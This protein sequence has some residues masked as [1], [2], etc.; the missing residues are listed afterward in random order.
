MIK[1]C[2]QKYCTGCTACLNICPKEC[3]QMVQNCDGFKYPKIEQIRCVKCG[4]CQK[5]CPSLS[6]KKVSTKTFNQNAYAATSRKSDVLAK[7]AS[8]GVFYELAKAI[9]NEGG[10]VFGAAYDE[11]MIVKHIPVYSAETLYLLQGTKYV[12]S[13]LGTCFSLVKKNLAEGRS[14]LFSGTPCQIAGLNGFLG[15]EAGN[16]ITCDLLCKG[17]PSPGLF[18]KYLN[19]LKKKYHREI[20]SVNFRSKKFGWGL[21][22]DISLDNGQRYLLKGIDDTFIRTAG[23]GFVREACFSCKFTSKSRISDITIGDFWHIGE[24]TPYQYDTQNGVSAIIVNTKKGESLF[25][26][27]ASSLRWDARDIEEVVSGQS[28]SLSHPL[29]KPNNYDQFFSDAIRL[30]YKDL[31]FKYLFDRSTKARIRRC[32]PRKLDKYITKFIKK[33]RKT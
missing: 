5:V 26:Q 1:L 27:I 24:Q 28:S 25:K 33:F 6:L 23:S 15:R 7:S 30:E 14:V 31:G 21:L 20:K 32:L 8:G 18:E 17:V 10:V 3:I 16:L 4:L 22:T 12:Q 9:L 19:Y 13:D 29:Q 2:E 11:N